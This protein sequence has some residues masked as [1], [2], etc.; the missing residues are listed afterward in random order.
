MLEGFNKDWIET[1]A[2]H[3]VATFTNLN[4]GKY[5][6]RVIGSNNKRVWNYEGAS[7][8]II[9]TPPWWETTLAYILYVLLIGLIVWLIW[10]AQL[11]RVHIRHELQMKQF[12]ADK[13]LELDQMKSRF[14]ANI[15]HEIRTPLTLILGPLEQLV[16]EATKEKWKNQLKIMSRNARNLLGLINQLL[17]FS[18]LESGKMT[19]KAKEL[20]IVPLLKGMV[21]SFDS[22]AKRKQ[23]TLAFTSEKEVI[24]VYI[25]TE[26]LE[27][28]MA[29]LLSNAFKFTADGGKIAVQLSYVQQGKKII[30]IRVTDTG[31]GIAP[32]H[33]N[34]IFDR[35]YR[36][37]DKNEKT[38]TGIG[39]ALTKELVELHYGQISVQSE[40]GKGTTF[41]IHLPRGKEYLKADEI[42][43]EKETTL[44]SLE[45]VQEQIE[46]TIEEAEKAPDD[47]IES[48]EKKKE[49]PVLLIVED[50]EDVRNYLRGFLAPHYKLEEAPDGKEGM[51]KAI[52]SLPDLV[53]SDVMMPKMDG[54]QLCEKLK[55]DERTSHIPVILL[56]A[57]AAEASKLEGL[58]TGADD[59]LVKP[60]SAK[61][62]TIRI[63]NLIDQRQKLRERFTRDIT[64]SPKDISVTSA[65]ERFLNRAIEIIENNMSDPDFDVD[66]FGKEIAFSHSQLRRKLKAL[67][68]QSPVE[69]IRTL[70][71]KR[72]ASLLEQAYG[73]VAEIS[74]EVGFNNPSYFA[75]CFRKQFGKS[76][77]EYTV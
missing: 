67:T 63:K 48:T 45:S 25:D 71:L 49:L 47:R 18:K 29:N 2:G 68:S 7:V 62:L 38:G 6:F 61:E 76:P 15:S 60:F 9:I 50:T 24:R 43:T 28:I 65:D 3:R 69:F 26:K 55:T 13:L 72:A 51:E 4:P 64:L 40:P 66:V 75:E 41:I 52:E 70:R 53:I 54:F 74:Y 58:E 17:D 59:Y 16:S 36:V 34:H 39:L 8:K 73:N 35:Y 32:E 33:L 42:D 10:K 5:I 20:N 14:F 1:D 19:L 37:D 23:I 22:L 12:E 44:P 11:R 46:S 31:I 77:S 21:Y 57:R 56:T 27:K 30:E